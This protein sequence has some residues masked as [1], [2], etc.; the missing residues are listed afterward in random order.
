MATLSTAFQKTVSTVTTQTSTKVAGESV[1]LTATPRADTTLLTGNVTFAIS[2]PIGLTLAATRQADGSY[3]ASWTPTAEGRYTVKAVF[4]ENERYYGSESNAST[5]YAVMQEH[6]VLALSAPA[7]VS[8]GASS[9]LTATQITSAA[10]G[11][12]SYEPVS[13]PTY[14]VQKLV[15]ETKDGKTTTSYQPA[16]KDTDYTIS[17]G[18]FTPRVVTTYIVTASYGGKTAD[19][20]I[21]VGKGTL[22]LAATNVS[23]SVNDA[24]RDDLT[25]TVTGLT[26]WDAG[27]VLTA[28]TDYKLSSPGTTATEK[29]EYSILVSLLSTA[30]V[31][32]LQKNYN[33]MLQNAVYTL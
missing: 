18:V 7:N 17:G 1:T 28:G 5:F 10:D 29:G 24:Q 2:G 27:T 23:H 16:V 9:T 19:A 3:T 6:T 15:S 21:S 11:S 22:T 25:A 32:A 8:Y 30:E 14:T 26:S 31:A 33:L 12:K 20:V 4:A 13:A